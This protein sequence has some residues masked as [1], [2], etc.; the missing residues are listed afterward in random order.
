MDS[1]L[2][3]AQRTRARGA[4]AG[5][6]AIVVALGAGVFW[7][8]PFKPRAPVTSPDAATTADAPNDAPQLPVI[9][10]APQAAPQTGA[11][12]FAGVDVGNSPVLR[13]INGIV[14][15]KRAEPVAEPPAKPAPV[16]VATARDVVADAPRAKSSATPPV[17]P[18]PA[19]VT[20]A[21]ANPPAANERSKVEANGRPNDAVLNALGIPAASQSPAGAA[22]PVTRT[23]SEA[24]AKA[25]V[26][27]EARPSTATP[28]SAPTA[29]P[30]PS[31]AASPAT[32]NATPA[33]DTT[34]VALGRVDPA[35][36]AAPAITP[37]RATRRTVPVFPNEAIKA[38]IKTGRV[39]ARVAIDADGHVTDSQILSARPPGYFE[40]ES[41]R[42]LSNWRYEAPGRSTSTDVE[43]L[44][45]RD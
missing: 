31:A 27:S 45:S 20:E 4:I 3:L 6:L 35:S 22:A 19:P 17:A 32:T 11:D 12:P 16:R 14:E 37:P 10:A 43:L 9:T 26:D 15:P 29:A 34:R 24:A 7:S 39:L 25:G 23:A 21:S 44:F 18:M 40:R 38:G 2:D 1:R 42:A 28:V 33:T 36:A 13:Y 5:K 41:Q 30:S 8:A